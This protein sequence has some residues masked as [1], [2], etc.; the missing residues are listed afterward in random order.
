M[1]NYST[2][3]SLEEFIV[4]KTN[5]VDLNL[6]VEDC[7]YLMKN[8]NKTIEDHLC[9]ADVAFSKFIELK[10]KLDYCDKFF[11]AMYAP[12]RADR[13]SY[14]A[15][16]KKDLFASKVDFM[17]VLYFISEVKF[18]V[19][20]LKN[21]KIIC[22]EYI[23]KFINKSFI[24]NILSEGFSFE[25]DLEVYKI[26]ISNYFLICDINNLNEDDLEICSHF[27]YSGYE[28]VQNLI[29]SFMY[30]NKIY[31]NKLFHKKE[32]YC[33]GYKYKK[34]GRKMCNYL[35]NNRDNTP[36]DL[37]CYLNFFV[38]CYS[39]IINKLYLVSTSST[40]LHSAKK[41]IR[42]SCLITEDEK[43]LFFIKID[44]FIEYFMEDCLSRR[45]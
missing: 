27:I 30:R 16:L 11:F 44:Y 37:L 29:V 42:S 28:G 2:N 33:L 41:I 36:D 32:I 45:R 31:E 17:A 35:L 15:S 20:L 7:K 22:K 26:L 19:A 39:D 1:Y 34:L 43:K 5:Y 40:D 13:M 21:L 8:F 10:P 23:K 4:G 18:E 3:L 9:L 12:Y 25:N 38:Y 6:Q 24:L 14:V